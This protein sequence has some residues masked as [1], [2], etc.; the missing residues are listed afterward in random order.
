MFPLNSKSFQVRSLDSELLWTQETTIPNM[1]RAGFLPSNILGEYTL[2]RQ[3][4][5]YLETN[6]GGAPWVRPAAGYFEC[7]M[8]F[9]SSRIYYCSY[10]TGEEVVSTRLRNCTKAHLTSK[11]PSQDLNSSLLDLKSIF[12]VLRRES[13]AKSSKRRL[14]GEVWRALTGYERGQPVSHGGRR[15]G[16]GGWKA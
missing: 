6:L 11:C 10:S 9:N 13:W 5:V 4:N 2:N 1:E 16:Y 15:N 7:I 3:A 8:W 14:N 12:Q